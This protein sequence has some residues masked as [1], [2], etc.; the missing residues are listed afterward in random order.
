MT[1]AIDTRL[2]AEAVT[3]LDRDVTDGPLDDLEQTLIC[4]ALIEAA[5]AELATVRKNLSARIAEAMPEKQVTIMGIGTFERHRK[6][7]RKRWDKDLLRIVL[8][9]K[10]ADRET[11][12]VR[13]E[14]PLD[15][16][17]HVWNLGAPRVTALRERDIEP[18]EWCT[19][20]YGGL[21]I[22]QVG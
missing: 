6:T 21:T 10:L 2:F 1:L 7:D 16:V 15:K 12:E 3:S 9:T 11:G 20:E 14:T 18:D 13:D 8:D 5:A 4:W 22:Q 17:L 19:T